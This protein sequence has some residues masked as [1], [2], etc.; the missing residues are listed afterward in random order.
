[1]ILAISVYIL[2]ITFNVIILSIASFVLCFAI[3]LLDISINI[4]IITYT[5]NK[6]GRA[7]IISHNAMIFGSCFNALLMSFLGSS[8]LVFIAIF[9]LLYSLVFLLIKPMKMLEEKPE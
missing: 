5:N 2:T 6:V 3:A 4:S 9:N 7:I 1:M 8:A